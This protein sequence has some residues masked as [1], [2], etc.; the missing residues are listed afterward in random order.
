MAEL[1]FSTSEIRLRIRAAGLVIAFLRGLFLAS[2]RSPRDLVLMISLGIFIRRAL[3]LST[4]LPSAIMHEP[5]MQLVGGPSK[6]CRHANNSVFVK[7]KN[8]SRRLDQFRKAVQLLL[9]D[10]C[11]FIGPE[12]G[13]NEQIKM[14]GWPL[15]FSS[16]RPQLCIYGL[17]F[18]LPF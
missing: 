11:I 15:F 1:K 9:E 17:L 5:K 7:G 18:F 12:N 3:S 16:S 4:S 6:Q 10:V 14:H 13:S 8:V 2:R